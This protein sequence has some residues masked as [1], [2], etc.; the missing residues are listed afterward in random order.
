M[1]KRTQFGTLEEVLELSAEIEGVMPCIDFCHLHAREGKENSYQEFTKILSRVEE[2]LGKEG[3]SNMHMHISGVE[4]GKNGE[5][6][7]LNLKESDFNYPILMK[8]L[9]EF[10]TRGRVI[11]E[12]PI[13]EQDALM[14]K[15]LYN[16]I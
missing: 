12:S 3:L 5:K 2:C 13:L 16:E 4:Y 7:H 14:L 6:K 15:Q 9:K 10:K 8:T 1:G 11:I